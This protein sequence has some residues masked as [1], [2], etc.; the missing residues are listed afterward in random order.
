LFD[1]VISQLA[2]YDKVIL[3]QAFEVAFFQF[4]PIFML[5]ARQLARYHALEAFILPFSTLVR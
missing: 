2:L 3:A 4:M 5:L 1:H